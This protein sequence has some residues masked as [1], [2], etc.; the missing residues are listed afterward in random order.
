VNQPSPTAAPPPSGTLTFAFTDIEGSAQ[1]WDRNRRAM[2]DAVRRHDAILRA[3]IGARR[4]YVFKTL[5][6]AFCAAFERPDDAVAAMLDA[7]R[8]LA[9]EDFAAVDGI[10]IR[11]AIHTGSADE[12][13]GDYVGPVLNR[14]ARLL[15]ISH[16]GQVVVSGVTADLVRD[17]LP[18]DVSL[19]DLGEHRLRDLARP[20]H[21]LQLVAPDLPDA[22][23][24]LRSLSV[25][26]NNLPRLLN[27]FVGRTR[28]I[29]EIIALIHR[30]PLVSLVGSGGL[31]K[32]RT[33]LQ[34]AAQLLDGTGDGVWFIEFAPL[35]SGDYIPSTIARALNITLPRDGDPLEDLVRALKPKRLL[36]IFDNCEHLLAPVAHTAAALLR[37]CPQLGILA[38]SRQPLGVTG[39]VTYRLPTLGVPTAAEAAR[40][41]ATAATTYAAIELFVERSRAVDQRFALTDENAPIIADICR[42]IDGIALAIELAA[43]RV[44]LL[45][46]IQLRDRLDERFRVLTGGS[47]DSLP[48]QQTLR[49]LIDWSYDLL[50]ERERVL[51]R[52]LGIFVNGF[53]LEAAMT[54]GAGDDIDELEV[55]DL[56]ESLVDKSLVLAEAEG[57]A[58]RYR[59]LESTRAYALEKLDAAGEH[60]VV[61]ARHLHAL[62]TRFS[63]LLAAEK[64]T[65]R[66]HERFAAFVIELDDIRAALAWGLAHGH[67][68]EGAQLLADLRRGFGHAGVEAEGLAWEESYL[69]ALPDDAHA[70][71]AHL[72]VTFAHALDNQGQVVRTLDV[73]RRAVEAARSANDPAVLLRA[74]NIS[75]W[76]YIHDYRSEAADRAITEAE[77]IPDPVILDRLN[78]MATRAMLSY[79]QADYATTV[80]VFTE[81]RNEQRALG[82]T[83]EEQRAAL[84]LANAELAR[85]EARRAIAVAREILPAIRRNNDTSLRA[86]VLCNLACALIAVDDLLPATEIAREVLLLLAPDQPNHRSVSFAIENMAL[87]F[88]IIGDLQRAAVLAGYS[89]AALQS[90]DLVRDVPEQRAYDRLMELLRAGLGRRDIE[91]FSAQGRALAATAAVALALQDEPPHEPHDPPTGT[92]EDA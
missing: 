9:A 42:R 37:T 80:R 5:G 6:D 26:P 13:D 14:I 73:A 43:S 33:S 19:R 75:A 57:D 7:Q 21:V 64:R 91:H 10:R 79:L 59:L 85:G 90:I 31:G 72:L 53:Q 68:R 65:A 86:C 29:D 20:E 15:F 38:S 22:F 40:L 27:A 77:S 83:T 70:L 55:V 87:V 17:A 92:V 47:R 1:R 61:A 58:Q 52:R 4:G 41:S 28:E 25:L 62:R 3:A 71:R 11:V 23:P 34:V 8:R 50:E 54:V 49:A 76:A 30:N 18:R 12:H 78:T 44:K 39:E 51:F 67:V 16:G 24:P 69:A 84:N 46:P 32:T 82:N 81:I 60:A 45:S 36:L 2:E 63:D 35:T 89:D 88:A 74:L 48:R 66:Q 56:L